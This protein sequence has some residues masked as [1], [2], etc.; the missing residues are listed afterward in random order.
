MTEYAKLDIL[1]QVIQNHPGDFIKIQE[2]ARKQIK[3]SDYLEINNYVTRLRLDG[4]IS[5]A[6]DKYSITRS[7]QTFIGYAQSYDRSVIASKKHLKEKSR[8][9]LFQ[10]LTQLFAITGIATSV[11]LGIIT[12]NLRSVEHENIKLKSRVELLEQS[13]TTSADQMP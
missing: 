9:M 12:Y 1:L 11:V 13:I 10:R 2:E 5:R 3:F 7:G 4:Y 6:D 8:R